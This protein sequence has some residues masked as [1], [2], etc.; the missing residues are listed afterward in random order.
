MNAFPRV[1]SH[2]CRSSRSK[3]Y[4]EAALSFAKN[5][6]NPQGR[7]REGVHLPAIIHTYQSCTI[8]SLIS[9]SMCQRKTGAI[10]VRSIEFLK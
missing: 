5:A 9:A 1:P 7:I 4:L 8:Q 10:H 2:Y 6:W 3:E